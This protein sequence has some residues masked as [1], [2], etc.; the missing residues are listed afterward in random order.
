[1]DGDERRRSVLVIG[2]IEASRLACSLLA[3]RGARVSH[4]LAP[5]DHE[6][7][8]A[9]GAHVD[10]VAILLRSDV[11]ALRYALLV[12]HLRPGT[13][14]VVT[15]F[16]RTLSSQ[17]ER[18]VA[19]CEVTSPADIAVPA[20]IGACLGDRM[21]AVYRSDDG[22]RVLRDEAD[23]VESVPYVGEPP[24]LRTWVHL[25]RGQLRPQDDASRILVAGLAG[26]LAILAA[27]WA[28]GVAFLG[29]GPVQSFYSA[30]RVVATVGPGVDELTSPRWYLIVSGTFMLAA[31]AFTAVFTAGIV[32]RLLSRRSIALLGRRTLPRRDHVVVV[33]L[34]QVGLRLATQLAAMGRRVVVVERDPAPA[35]LR[36]AKAA[37][38]PVVIGNG[39]ERA[40]LD[41]LSLGRARA[42]AA[43]GSQELDNV[44]VAI[45]ARA[46][47]PDLAI[48]LRA[49][50][51][52]AIAETQSL[53]A[54]GQVRDVSALT[55]AAVALGLTSSPPE[56]VYARGH[57]VRAHPGALDVDVVR[58]CGC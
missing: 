26:L 21:L 58:R 24:S 45:T 13:R 6:V 18:A 52:D 48:V 10:A 41:R 47:A 50:E 17:L 25:L 11:A 53:F 46:V 43:M 36:I 30:T 37:R 3:D 35:N 2:D 44:E 12:A 8:A 16:D 40:V 15:M 1:M 34:G 39:S 32:N 56:V 38:I 20:I 7:R 55:A 31:I 33:G 19:N 49:G 42:L 51:H 54:V 22:L 4:L 27:D 28:L 23:G 9:L 29:Q 5:S 14:L 57:H